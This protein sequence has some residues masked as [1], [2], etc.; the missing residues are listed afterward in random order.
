MIRSK[1]TKTVQII[2]PVIESATKDAGCVRIGGGM[3]HF[4]DEAPAR[5][6]T[7]DAGRVRIGGG[8][9]QF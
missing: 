8:M 3:I 1:E 5:E 2:T 9:I 6:V 4:A 7:K